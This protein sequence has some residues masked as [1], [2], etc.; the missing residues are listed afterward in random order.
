M[1]DF[2][3]SFL[4]RRMSIWSMGNKKGHLVSDDPYSMKKLSN[5]ISFSTK[6]TYILGELLSRHDMK[7]LN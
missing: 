3:G 6:I 7:M 4:S 1:D 5:Y 2:Q